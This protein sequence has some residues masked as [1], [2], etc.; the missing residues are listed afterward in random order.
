MPDK[1]GG[2][3]AEWEETLSPPDKDEGAWVQWK[4]LIALNNTI[5]RLEV[6]VDLLAER[7]KSTDKKVQE[8]QKDQTQTLVVFERGKTALYIIGALGAVLGG[9]A[10]FG[11]DIFVAL[12]K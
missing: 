2:T 4:D 9:L 6:K 3:F 7:I 11:K 1:N 5:A 10:S 12:H 8:L